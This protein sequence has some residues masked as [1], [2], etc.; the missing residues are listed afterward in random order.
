MPGRLAS[1]LSSGVPGN[2]L[3]ALQ[4]ANA[5]SVEGTTAPTVTWPLTVSLVCVVSTALDVSSDA[6][7]YGTGL[8]IT[9]S[10][11][12]STPLRLRIRASTVPVTGWPFSRAIGTCTQWLAPVA[13]FA[14]T[15]VAPALSACQPLVRPTSPRS[16]SAWTMTIP[17]PRLGTSC[18]RKPLAFDRS[19]GLVMVNEVS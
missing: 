7:R 12:E 15:A 9:L 13:W 11:C 1:L 6:G 8:P 4:C 5:Q 18:H 3:A 2:G 19:T 14:G 17:P 10:G 16:R